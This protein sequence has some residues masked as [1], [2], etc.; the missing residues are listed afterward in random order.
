MSMD[1]SKY[2]DEKYKKD[3]YWGLEPNKYVANYVLKYVKAGNALDLGSGEGRDAIFLAKSGFDVTAVD[4][5]DNGVKKMLELAKQLK[6][7]VKGVVSDIVKLDFKEEYDVILSMAIFN[8]LKREDVLKVI[9]RMKEH[10]K[11]GGI[12]VIMAFTEDNPLKVFPY[13]FKKGEIKA[14]YDGWEILDYLEIMDE[15]HRDEPD[16]KA[17]MHARVFLTAKKL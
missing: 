14:L 9:S 11:V 8:F 13:L 3:N 6:V 1:V 16:K 12:N 2:Y 17:H 10:T 5:S 4:I 15:P 7:N